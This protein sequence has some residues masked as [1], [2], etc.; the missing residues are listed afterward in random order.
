MFS[1]KDILYIVISFCIIWTTVFLCWVF[2]YLA[3]VLKNASRIT[4]EFRLRLESLTSAIDHVRGRVEGI[5]NMLTLVVEGATGLIKRKIERQ[6]DEFIDKGTKKF[7]RAAK[8][9]VS[10]AAENMMGAA[11][12][13]RKS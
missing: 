7:N 6:A 5:S 3:R 8:E 4:E 9:A 10:A 11:K 12:K 2:Y 13:I 1:S